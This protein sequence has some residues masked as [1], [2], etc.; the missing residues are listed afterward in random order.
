MQMFSLIRHS[1]SKSAFE[2]ERPYKSC[3]QQEKLAR[4]PA[5]TVQ[6][7]STSSMK[8]MVQEDGPGEQHRTEK[9]YK[10]EKRVS[11][12]GVASRLNDNGGAELQQQLRTQ[13]PYKHQKIGHIIA[14]SSFS[15]C[16]IAWAALASASLTS[17][18]HAWQAQHDTDN[19]PVKPVKIMNMPKTAPLQGHMA[20]QMQLLQKTEKSVP[21]L[22]Q[23]AGFTL[24]MQASCPTTLPLT[25]HQSHSVMCT[26]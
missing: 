13:V 14:T 22:S 10:R 7:P 5:E 1:A 9:R 8:S 20:S 4:V 3:W 24:D 2:L 19:L 6:S 15:A 21:F 25:R 17:C 23:P 26:R 12:W 16:H 11:R 18:S